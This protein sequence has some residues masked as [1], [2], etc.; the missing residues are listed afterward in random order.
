M[1][2]WS[3]GYVNEINYTAG[4]Y[5]HL[6]PQQLIVPFLMAG[7]QPP[8][9]VNACELGFGLGTSLNIHAAAGRAKWYATDFNPS[10]ALHAQSLA[11]GADPSKVL[12]ADQSFAEF[13][14][15]DDLPMFDYIGLHG[16]W[17]WISN[18]NRKIIVDFLARKLKVGG[19]LYISYNTLPGWSANAPLRHLFSQHYHL[20]SSSEQNVEINIKKALQ[21]TTEV[22]NKSQLLLGQAT[23]LKERAESLNDSS[24][25]YLAHEYLNKDWHPMYFADMM[26]FLKEAKLSYVCSASFLDDYLDILLDSEQRQMLAEI[27]DESLKQ[28]TKDFFLNKQFRRDYWVRGKV[29]LDTRQIEQNW[30]Q[31]SVLLTKPADK[32]EREIK[33][34]YTINFK[35]ELL[36]PILQQLSDH[37]I[38][39]VDTLCQALEDSIPANYIFHILAILIARDEV[40]LAQPR[41]VIEQQKSATQ[42]LNTQIL[43]RVLGKNQ[44]DYLASPVSGGGIHYSN[45]EM[46]FL[47]AYQQNTPVEAWERFA[48]ARL[49]KL[50]LLLVHE[51]QT[52]QGEA[53]NLAEL[54]RLKDIFVAEKLPIALSLQV[55]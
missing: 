19:V 46:L 16:I 26:D 17:S 35:E 29:V 37:Q 7:V 27:S 40:M 41:V 11:D 24:V 51:G 31:L 47:L 30:R 10:Q 55:V 6:N 43:E 22:L 18:Q 48:W 54:T 53:E 15:R 49:Q 34:Y 42:K 12:I 32:V 9:V 20:L 50:G 52:L 13:C 45:I 44:I 21:K 5:T 3:E 2:S 4:Y 36:E 33:Y 8:K 14:Q 1:S 38:H 23:S 39:S 28:T 25:N